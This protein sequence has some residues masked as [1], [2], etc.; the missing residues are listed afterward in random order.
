MNKAE[1]KKPSQLK[2]L[3]PL[4]DESRTPE[5]KKTEEL[6][7]QSNTETKPKI[8]GQPTRIKKQL[9]ISEDRPIQ[10]DKG[11]TGNKEEQPSPAGLPRPVSFPMNMSQ[12]SSDE[13]QNAVHLQR[14]NRP[15]RLK[16]KPE[17]WKE[18]SSEVAHMQNVSDEILRLQAKRKTGLR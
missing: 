5:R 13:T 9:S 14:H 18:R 11:K 1:E 17:K 6:S 2:P 16:E 10:D 15:T 8:T 4:P 7:Q 12:S 3:P